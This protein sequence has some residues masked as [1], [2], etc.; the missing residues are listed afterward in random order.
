MATRRT[1][2]KLGVA[3]GLAPAL[4]PSIASAQG[5]GRVVVVGGGFGGAT[6]A[7]TLKTL[8]PT[9]SVTLVEPNATYTACP[10]SNTVL[11]NLRPMDQQQFGYDS[12]TKAGV[13]VAQLSATAVNASARTVTL[14]DGSALPYDRLV[15]SPGIDFDW[16]AIPGYDEAASQ[17]MPHAW[18]AGPQTVLLRQQLQNM[19][20]GG[21]VVISSPANPYRCPPGPYERA[22]LI[23][24]WLKIWKPKSKLL[25]LDSKDAFSKQ[26]L[27]Q[28]AWAQ[29]YP[30]M[31]DWVSLSKGGK[32]TSV[33]PSTL[34]LVT[35]F[36]RH[37]A[38]VANVIPPQKAGAIA[39]QAGVA[40]RTGWC[41]VEP[42]AF[43]STLQ[44][45][46][47]VLGDAAIMGA[48]PKSAFAANAQGKVCAAAIVD[49]L[50]GRKPQDP[51]LINT[52][53]SLV[54]ADY[55]ISVAGV[56][57]P[58]KGVLA[59]VPGSGG[60]SP[61]E[62]VGGFRGQEALYASSWF[63]TITAEVFG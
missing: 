9:L 3:A 21:L 32:V 22:S 46:I 61:L 59:D 10:F 60:V 11:A 25:I 26:R 30:G 13:T 45:G 57:R 27:F 62:V 52:C 18:K 37:K 1:F 51:I 17:I 41:P 19:D 24:Y 6:A 63:R 38:A 54:A 53:Y 23:A 47:H 44:P 16:K 50:A 4:A 40:D 35:D 42:V 14:S 8:A 33:D 49:L 43:E 34:T 15:L 2:L 31:I 55:A 28:N 12:V 56:Y 5:A 20:D 7:R 58:D 39:H 48:M 29:L 36:G